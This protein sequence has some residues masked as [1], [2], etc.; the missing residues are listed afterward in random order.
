MEAG[1]F[2]DRILPIDAII[3]APYNG[4]TAFLYQINRP[5]WPVVALPL[6]E[7]VGDYGVTNYVSVN[8]DNQTNWVLRH[9][10]I[11]EDNSKFIIADLTKIE[12][13]LDPIKDP[14]P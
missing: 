10:K 3:V 7:M 1:K 12:H 9:F 2:A 11:L 8:R 4:D 14:E 5:G 13:P 6:P